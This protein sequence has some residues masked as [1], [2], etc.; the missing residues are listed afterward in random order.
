MAKNVLTSRLSIRT[1]VRVP[2]GGLE[3]RA[4]IDI[5]HLWNAGAS[6]WHVTKL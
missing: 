1:C 4:V 6:F 5:H 3:M 2:D